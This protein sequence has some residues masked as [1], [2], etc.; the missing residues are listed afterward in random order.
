M[1][2]ETYTVS[3]SN[4]F[5]A[6]VSSKLLQTTPRI[7]SYIINNKKVLSRES[8]GNVFLPD[9]FVALVTQPARCKA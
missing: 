4:E 5:T 9:I 6:K 1:C 8:C 7:A 3:N 2:T